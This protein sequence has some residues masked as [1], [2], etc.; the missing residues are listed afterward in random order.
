MVRV[1][2]EGDGV[3]WRSPPINL[4]SAWQAQTIPLDAFERQERGPDGFRVVGRGGVQDV[5]TWSLKVGH[6]MNPVDAAGEIEID[7]L[8]FE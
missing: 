7:E 5:R 1:F 6:F 8:R 2:L 3:R 4:T